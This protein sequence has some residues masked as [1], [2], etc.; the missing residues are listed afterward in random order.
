VV[1]REFDQA[2]GQFSPDGQWVAYAVANGSRF[3]IAVPAGADASAPF[4]I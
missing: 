3:L 1:Q 2:Q 4:T